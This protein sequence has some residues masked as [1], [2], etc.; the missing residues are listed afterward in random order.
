MVTAVHAVHDTGAITA[1]PVVVST[2]DAVVSKFP[3]EKVSLPPSFL[4]PAMAG[5]VYDQCQM[6]VLLYD[7]QIYILAETTYQL[8]EA[9]EEVRRLA[10]YL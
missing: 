4:G 10:R 8:G 5:V 7:S 1:A 9:G 3:I 2:P 6:F